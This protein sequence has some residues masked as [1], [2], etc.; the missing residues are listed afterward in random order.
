MYES[1]FRKMAL[2]SLPSERW[3]LDDTSLQKDDTYL[4]SFFSFG[5]LSLFYFQFLSP[6]L[7]QSDDHFTK[8]GHHDTLPR[9]RG[10]PSQGRGQLLV[11]NS[12][13]LFSL[14]LSGNPTLLPKGVAGPL[15]SP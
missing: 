9:G 2:T 11:L 4:T 8:L 14:N 5:N 3:H 7:D 15:R 13:I 6:K 10:R 1:H 12:C